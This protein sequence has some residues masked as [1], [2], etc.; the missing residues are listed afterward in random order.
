ME[1][2]D[3]LNVGDLVLP[4]GITTDEDSDDV[5]FTVSH[6]R[7]AEEEETE[8]AAEGEVAVEAADTEEEAE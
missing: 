3:V 6:E 7:V 4:E 5:V 2:G 8:E 1:A